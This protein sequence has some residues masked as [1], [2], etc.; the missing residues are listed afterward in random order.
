[1]G[2]RP[3]LVGEFEDPGFVTV[4]ALQG[5]GFMCTPTIVMREV[6]A[7]FG[8]RPIGRT[9]QCQQQFYAITAERKLTHPAVVAITAQARGRLFANK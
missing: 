4:L 5:L 3:R 7:R 2:V 8:L 9:N 1:M 6:I